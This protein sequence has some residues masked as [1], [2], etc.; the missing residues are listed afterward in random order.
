[1]RFTRFVISNAPLLIAMVGL[2]EV[3]SGNP[4]P[5]TT[6]SYS[7][8]AEAL[9]TI[10][11]YNLPTNLMWFSSALAATCWML[12][13]RVGDIPGR[14]A[15]FIGAVVAVALVVTS[16]GALID[17]T[18]LLA[19]YP[20]GYVLYYDPVNWTAALAL[21]F[22]SI[23]LSSLLLLNLDPRVALIPAIAIAAMNLVWW[24][25]SIDSGS[26]FAL[27]TMFVFLVLVPFS[28]AIL[29]DWHLR[30]FPRDSLV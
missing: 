24:S 18:L 6:Q 12:G 4:G 25:A 28:L 29:A 30:K 3:V 19:E 10:F 7:S 22:A 17:F 2:S 1:L 23:Y 27:V 20:F 5:P 11:I 21:I 16:L 14:T 15:V 13:R 9:S 26:S 8:P